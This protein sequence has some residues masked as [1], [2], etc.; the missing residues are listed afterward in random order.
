MVKSETDHTHWV[1]KQIDM[2]TMTFDER[3]RVKEETKL[4]QCLNHPNI[5]KF[6]DHFKDKRGLYW[7][8]VMEHADGGDMA[9]MIL[10][11]KKNDNPFSEDEVL[12]YFTQVCL[13]IK[14]CHDRKIVHRDIK[15]ANIFLTTRGIVKVGDFGASKVLSSTMAKAMT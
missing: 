15:A 6:K 12:D 2:K 4:L 13:A 9:K 5:I 7:N 3:V 11:R 8:T 1:L 10:E 14:H